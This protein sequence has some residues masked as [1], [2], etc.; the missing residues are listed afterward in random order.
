MDIII[1]Y[2]ALWFLY[3]NSNI[4]TKDSFARLYPETYKELSKEYEKQRDQR[5]KEFQENIQK[6]K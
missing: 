6:E 3:R 5:F 1:S 2:D 4:N